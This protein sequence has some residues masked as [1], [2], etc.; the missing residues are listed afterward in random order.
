METIRDRLEAL[1]A[2]SVRLP[3]LRS[4]QTT[5]RSGERCSVC[6]EPAAL[7]LGTLAYCERCSP[8][9]RIRAEVIQPESLNGDGRRCGVDRPLFG[10]GVCELMC[11]ACGAS[12]TGPEG[13]A[14]WWCAAARR[15][16]V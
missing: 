10:P 1:P 8:I 7:T 5:L 11:S 9:R 16:L 3:V 4:G 14:C 13:E 6:G 12:W 2:E 15:W